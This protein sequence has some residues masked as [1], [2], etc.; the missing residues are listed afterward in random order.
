MTESPSPLIFVL[1]EIALANNYTEVDLRELMTW[2]ADQAQVSPAMIAS[3]SAALMRA[4]ADDPSASVDTHYDGR[5][6]V[7]GSFDLAQ[8]M[9]RALPELL[10]ITRT[11]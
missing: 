10:K 7:V 1:N 9:A 4:L 6:E 3:A 11:T 2:S 8:V 5:V